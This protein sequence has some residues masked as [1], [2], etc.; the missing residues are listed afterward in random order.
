MFSFLRNRFLREMYLTSSFNF[1]LVGLLFSAFIRTSVNSENM[2]HLVAFS[3]TY[4]PPINHWWCLLCPVSNHKCNKIEEGNFANATATNKDGQWW[5]IKTN[6]CQWLIAEKIL[7]CVWLH[8][9]QSSKY[10]LF[11]CMCLFA[12]VGSTLQPW[13]RRQRESR[14][15]GGQP[16]QQP[17]GAEPGVGQHG[18]QRARLHTST[19]WRHSSHA[20]HS[21]HWPGGGDEGGTCLSFRTVTATHTRQ[22]TN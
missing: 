18:R 7:K 15:P 8:S 17:L 1:F 6:R 2:M 19:A 22:R 12:C 9:H 14:E 11:V 13:G 16:E 20:P 3:H 21:P 10:L 5:P 4:F